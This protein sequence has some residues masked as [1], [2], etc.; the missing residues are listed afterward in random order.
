MTARADNYAR[1]VL[2][3]LVDALEQPYQHPQ[4][5]TGFGRLA[6]GLIDTLDVVSDEERRRLCDEIP[7]L[8]E[9]ADHVHHISDFVVQYP[10]F[11]GVDLDLIRALL[12]LL[13]TMAVFDRACSSG[14]AAR[15][16][17]PRTARCWATSSR[18]RRTTSPG[19]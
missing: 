14:C 13:S 18:G 15:T 12:Y 11:H 9:L 7:D 4:P 8:S 16:S 1:Y 19:A 6:R 2:S 5:L 3:N 10:Q 17:R